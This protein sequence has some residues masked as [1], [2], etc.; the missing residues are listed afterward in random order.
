M[1]ERKPIIKNSSIEN[2]KKHQRINEQIN[3]F[4]GSRSNP[5]GCDKKS[6]CKICESTMHFVRNCPNEDSSAYVTESESSD[7]ILF[8]GNQNNK[9]IIFLTKELLYSV[10]LDS[11]C[12]STV[13]GKNWIYRYLESSP[14]D[15]GISN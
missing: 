2:M 7:V 10:V 11:G 6:S 15:S 4:P 5:N 8:T 3:S 12:S 14:E 13:A 9:G 1:R